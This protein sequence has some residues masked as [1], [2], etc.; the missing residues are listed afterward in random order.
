MHR[1]GA[2]RMW[3]FGPPQELITIQV[4][5]YTGAYSGLVYIRSQGGRASEIPVQHQRIY[6][7][8][9]NVTALVWFLAGLGLAAYW[10]IRLVI[11]LVQ[12]AG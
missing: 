6:P 11:M 4:L 3:P 9:F 10:F 1:V 7:Q 8:W 2:S 12:P 5:S